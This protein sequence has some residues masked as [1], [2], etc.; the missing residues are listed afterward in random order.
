MEIYNQI[1]KLLE[2]NQ[3]FVLATIIHSDGSVPG[4]VGFKL[5]YQSNRK[6]WG[7]VGG[8]AIE[9]EVMKECETRLMSNISGSKEY[10]LTDKP[11]AGKKIKISQ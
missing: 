5:L 7:T 2:E 9:K 1:T 6:M 11:L 8:G 3:S 10:L 4:K